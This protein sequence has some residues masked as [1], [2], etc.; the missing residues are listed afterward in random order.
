MKKVSNL[1]SP[2][3]AKRHHDVEVD[4]DSVAWKLN[5]TKE[6]LHRMRAYY[7]ANVEMID[8]QVGNILNSHLKNE[9][10]WITLSQYLLRITDIN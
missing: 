3:I 7:Y 8:T 6:E 10:I 9:E 5:P 2:W 1:V 4:H